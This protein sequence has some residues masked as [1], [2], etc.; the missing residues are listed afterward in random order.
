MAN[1]ELRQGK[2]S[3]NLVGAVK[4]H[5]LKLNKG[6]DGQY[7]NGSLVIKTGEFSEVELSVYVKEK[8]KDGSVKKVFETLESVIN[9]EH[10]TMANAKKEDVVTKVKVFGN[11]DFTPHFKEDMF[12]TEGSDEV[13]TKIKCDLG[14]GSVIVDNTLTEEDYR[15]EFDV[16]V[17]V[18][19]IVEEVKNDEATGRAK[20]SG[21]L[22]VYGGKV[23]PLE[24][25]AGLVEDEGETIDFGQEILNNVEIGSTINL[26]GKINYQQIVTTTKKGGGLGKAKVEEKR[27]YINELIVE[28][29]EV[30]PEAT[31]FNADLVKKALIERDNAI[32]EKK[33][34]QSTEGK[35]KT[36]LQGAASSE[37]KPRRERPKF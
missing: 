12:K 34:E 26:W 21:L 16:E 22:P 28:G 10:K 14:F 5:K 9:E 7:I 25:I 31:E 36:G 6:D 15:A 2:N 1:Q 23:I 19:N 24:L 32:E 37:D 35:K 27:T 30:T 8:K 20:I 13:K 3:I 33:N 29:G 18:R 11:G 4:E 17:Y